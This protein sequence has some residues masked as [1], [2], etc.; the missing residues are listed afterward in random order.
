MKPKWSGSLV[1]VLKV[2]LIK[3]QRSGFLRGSF[4]MESSL[5]RVIQN[6][7]EKVDVRQ[8]IILL[9]L[10]RWNETIKQSLAL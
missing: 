10:K 1:Q 4:F 6:G 2:F 3:N 8:Q 9:K 5:G 7:L